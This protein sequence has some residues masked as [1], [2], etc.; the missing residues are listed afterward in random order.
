MFS[1][2]IAVSEVTA[3]T[4][5]RKLSDDVHAD[6]KVWAAGVRGPEVL[7]DLDG[8]E[9]T[10]SNRLIV[11]QTLQT[12]RDDP[13]FAIVDCCVVRLDGA[14][15]PVPPRAQDGADSLSKH[16][17][18]PRQCAPGVLRLSRSWVVG[19]LGQ[20]F[21]CRLPDGQPHWQAGRRSRIALPTRPISRCT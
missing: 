6:I 18:S 8:L 7:R 3:T 14:A 19:L 4:L 9:V 1:L 10:R 16:S 12:T 11:P 17:P 15:R 13:I 5:K 21:D 2:T 20:A